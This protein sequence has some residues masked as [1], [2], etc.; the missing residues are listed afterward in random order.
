MIWM[1][2]RGYAEFHG[3]IRCGFVSAL[4][5]FANIFPLSSNHSAEGHRAALLERVTVEK[6][7]IYLHRTGLRMY[8]YLYEKLC[9]AS[10]S[11]ETLVFWAFLFG[12]QATHIFVPEN[13]LHVLWGKF[14][15][16]ESLWKSKFLRP[17]FCAVVEQKR[18]EIKPELNQ[19]KL[20]L[21][22]CISCTRAVRKQRLFLSADTEQ[23]GFCSPACLDLHRLS[24]VQSVFLNTVKVTVRLLQLPLRLLLLSVVKSRSIIYINQKIYIYKFLK[25]SMRIDL[26][27]TK[28]CSWHCGLPKDRWM[29]FR[30]ELWW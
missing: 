11:M 4:L 28:P 13:Q 5:G 22:K 25:P 29:S 20:L 15:H 3:C 14:A 24:F 6:K 12:Y 10:T 1:W 18:E 16:P 9:Y 27:M 7:N 19:A 21:N 30:T 26:R 23:T 2:R 8:I 17:C